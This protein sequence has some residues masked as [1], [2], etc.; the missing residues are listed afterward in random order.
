MSVSDVPTVAVGEVPDPGTESVLL[1]VRED[2]E[3]ELGHAPG[4][5]HIPLADLPSR[6]DDVDIDAE[7]YVVCRQG[8]RS[9]GA[10]QYLNR[11]GFDAYQVDGGMV[12]WQQQGLPLVCDG[13]APAKIY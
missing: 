7:V 10:V 1:D 9:I 3:W 11:I 2:D 6:V 5:L 13:D 12:A 4:A 8:G